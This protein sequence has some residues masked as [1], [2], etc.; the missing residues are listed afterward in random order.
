MKIYHGIE[1][2]EKIKNAVVT[3]GTFD[4]VHHGHQAILHR[5]RE[6][7]NS[8]HG[9]TVVITYWPHPRMVL[10]PADTSLKLLNTFEEKAL[11]LEDA[12]TDHLL[13]IPFTK[14]FSQLSSDEFVKK[15]L[16][17]KIGTRKLVIGYDHHFGKNREGSFEQLRANAPAYGFEVEEIPRQLIDDVAVSST[18][19]REALERGD[20]SEARHFLGRNYSLTG[21]VV[22]GD[23]IGRTIGYPTANIQVDSV[24][25]LIPMDG[26]Y[27]VRVSIGKRLFSGMLY[28]GKRPTLNATQQVIEVNLFDFDEDIYGDTVTLHFH[29]FLRGDEK[30]QDLDAL[31]NQLA[32]DKINALHALQN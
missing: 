10:N 21:M 20:V 2:F 30:F 24:Y 19:I 32:K 4:G 27:A 11:L 12:G 15:I 1:H 28:I 3:S 26:I 29:S 8:I 17:D 16:I 25:K 13:R 14:D 31:K 22:R 5:L 23:Q 18:R 6:S 7:A 9:E